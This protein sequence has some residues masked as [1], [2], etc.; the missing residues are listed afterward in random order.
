M[1]FPQPPAAPRHLRS[2]GGRLFL[3]DLLAFFGQLADAIALRNRRYVA[4]TPEV[5]GNVLGADDRRQ[6]AQRRNQFAKDEGDGDVPG[7]RLNHGVDRRLK[8]ERQFLF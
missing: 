5:L 2:Q 3:D 6:I 8:K 7:A 1:D 4:S